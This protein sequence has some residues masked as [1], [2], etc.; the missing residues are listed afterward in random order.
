[1]LAAKGREGFDGRKGRSLRPR[2]EALASMKH[3]CGVET[4]GTTGRGGPEDGREAKEG[5]ASEG[6]AAATGELMR[7]CELGARPC[8]L[9]K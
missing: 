5:W 6:A 7:I 9:R 2:P 4:C 3:V 1:M 8:K